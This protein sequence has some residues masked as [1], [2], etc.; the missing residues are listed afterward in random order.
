MKSLQV[1]NKNS[2]SQ[3]EMHQNLQ[4]ARRKICLVSTWWLVRVPPFVQSRMSLPS[5]LRTLN[6]CTSGKEDTLSLVAM[7]QSEEHVCSIYYPKEQILISEWGKILLYCF[8]LIQPSIHLKLGS[9]KVLQVTLLRLSD[10]L[11]YQILGHRV[12]LN[13]SK[14]CFSFPCGPYMGHLHFQVL[15]GTGWECPTQSIFSNRFLVPS[16]SCILPVAS[17]K[18]V[19]VVVT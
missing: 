16:L 6:M 18:E 15:R 14:P 10:H 12:P 4:S 3:V 17:W 7:W 9:D 13:L 8:L 5:R 11:P 1:R 19:C 2:S